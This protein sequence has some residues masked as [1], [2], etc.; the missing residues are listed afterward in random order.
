M[1]TLAN[2]EDPDKI[3]SYTAFYQG[4]QSLLRQKRSSEKEILFYLEIITCDTSI[5]TMTNSK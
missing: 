4:L 3:Y 1:S 5:H 2:S